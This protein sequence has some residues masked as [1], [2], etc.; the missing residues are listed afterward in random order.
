MDTFCKIYF[1]Q[2]LM[3]NINNSRFYNWE[4]HVDPIAK[5]TVA[6]L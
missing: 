4:A 3:S 2:Q 1:L 5:I 6:I